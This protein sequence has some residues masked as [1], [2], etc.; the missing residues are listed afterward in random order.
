MSKQY[1][2]VFFDLDHTL[3]DFERN[4]RL[5][6]GDLFAHFQLDQFGIVDADTFIREYEVIN[7][8][9]WRQYRENLI[10]RITL[11]N[12]R[13]KRVFAHWNLE[14]PDIA[15][16]IN[17]LYLQESPKKTHLLPNALEVLD[18]LK[19]KYPLHLITNG[20]VEVQYTK[21]N[22]SGLRPYFQNITTS[23]EAGYLKPDRR[24]FDSAMRSAGARPE[25]S[26]YIGDHFETDVI[27]SRNAGMD[28]VHFNTNGW[29]GREAPTYEIV[30]LKELIDIL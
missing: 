24:V 20:F 1:Q 15:D 19:N 4:S 6:L 12:T 17:E 14:L 16:K 25:H 21:L 11:R 30:D 23:E 8:D 10:D 28:Q 9:L 7:A 22:G 29:V 3:W 2:H 26:I 5:T 18:Y 27:G 13:F